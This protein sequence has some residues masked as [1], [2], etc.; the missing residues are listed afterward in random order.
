MQV[1]QVRI[2]GGGA[3]VRPTRLGKRR[4]F[5][6]LSHRK[7]AMHAPSVRPAV[8][9]LLLRLSP[10]PGVAIGRAY[11]GSLDV[12]EPIQTKFS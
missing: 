9:L 11:D 8:A 1:A 2:V 10:Q 12:S 5:S 6:F 4:L 7:P 3:R